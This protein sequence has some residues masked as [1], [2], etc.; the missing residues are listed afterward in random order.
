MKN[1]SIGFFLSLAAAAVALIAL[2]VYFIYAAKNGVNALIVVS[3]IVVIAA[4]LCAAACKN[5]IV[6]AYLPVIAP[7]FGAVATFSFVTDTV[8]TFADFFT[9]VGIFGDITQIGII[10]AICILSL[11]AS[12]LSIVVC[13]FRQEKSAPIKLIKE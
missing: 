10:T 11:V 5:K 13:F 8:G 3:L 4:E 2:I 6:A 7:V 1:K 9:G 12:L